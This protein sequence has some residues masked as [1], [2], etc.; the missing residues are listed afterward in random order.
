[1]RGSHNEGARAGLEVAQFRD[2]LL[3]RGWG[4]YTPNNDVYYQT[5][6]RAAYA[7][8]ESGGPLLPYIE[9]AFN[10]RRGTIRQ[11]SPPVMA[12][13]FERALHSYALDAKDPAHYPRDY[14]PPHPRALDNCRAL[15]LEAIH[16]DDEHFGYG[17]FQQKLE[18]QVPMSNEP[19]RGIGLKVMSLLFPERLGAHPKILEPGCSLNL[20][21]KW[22]ANNE[23]R[24]STADS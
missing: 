19:E 13:L 20:I 14:G 15:I 23:Q 10:D 11:I 12:S 16:S 1:M 7:A 4:S 21:L 5:I 24:A 6:D 9:Q 8:T 18:M 22:L 17:D 2:I 3:R